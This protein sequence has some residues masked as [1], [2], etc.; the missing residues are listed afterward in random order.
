MKKK[1]FFACSMRGGFPY[2]SR[3]FLAQ[4]PDAL[5]DIGLELMSRHQT[6]QGVIQRENQITTIE[7]HDRDYAWLEGCEFVVA[8]ISNPSDGVGG[9]IADAIHLGK[10]VLALYQRP[11][12]E[13]S[14]YTRGKLEGYRKGRHTE[15]RDLDHLKEIVK[16][17]IWDM[18]I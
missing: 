3:E 10:P 11:E 5:E 12:D 14:A 7:I 8:E 17:F 13:I 15:Y 2:V 18:G 6:Q 4:I 9:E 1:V 16:E